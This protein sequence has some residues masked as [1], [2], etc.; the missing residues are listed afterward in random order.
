M[1]LLDRYPGQIIH[2]DGGITISIESVCHRKVRVGID[3]PKSVNIVR[4]EIRGTT[5]D[6]GN[7]VRDAVSVDGNK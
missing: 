6:S 2:I 1:L 5:K 7:V 4:G 3:A